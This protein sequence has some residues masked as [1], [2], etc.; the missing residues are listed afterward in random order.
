MEELENDKYCGT[1]DH[2]WGD[3]DYFCFK[4]GKQGKQVNGNNEPC[5]F[6]ISEED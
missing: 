5:E 1:C 3:G 4:D 6:W 2:F